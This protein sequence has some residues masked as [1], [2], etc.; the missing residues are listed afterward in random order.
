MEVKITEINNNMI[1]LT[2]LFTCSQRSIDYSNSGFVTHLRPG[3]LKTILVIRIKTSFLM[4]KII[5]RRTA[6]M[7]PKRPIA[8]PKIST[9]SILTKSAGLAASERAAPDPT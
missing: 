5:T 9:M 4:E 7:R 6:M 3:G 1:I 8:L 2:R